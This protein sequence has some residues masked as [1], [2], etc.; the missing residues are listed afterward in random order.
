MFRRQPPLEGD[1]SCHVEGVGHKIS[2][3][4]VRFAG[5]ELELESTRTVS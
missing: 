5:K 3:A 1:G 4:D 2:V